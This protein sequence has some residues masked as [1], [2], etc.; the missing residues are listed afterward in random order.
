MRQICQYK[1][2]SKHCLTWFNRVCRDCRARFP[3]RVEQHSNEP[4]LKSDNGLISAE[5][6]Y[7]RIKRSAASHGSHGFL[8]DDIWWKIPVVLLLCGSFLILCIASC[9]LC[10]RIIEKMQE[11]KCCRRKGMVIIS[12]TRTSNTSCN[13]CKRTRSNCGNIWKQRKTQQDF[14]RNVYNSILD[15]NCFE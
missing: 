12:G 6:C 11:P 15:W 9:L 5:E 10:Q 1:P 7:A 8:T 4:M 3:S 13:S 14:K 2:K